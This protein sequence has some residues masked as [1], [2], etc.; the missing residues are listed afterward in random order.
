MPVPTTALES[1]FLEESPY[2]SYDQLD[3]FIGEDLL[4]EGQGSV[5]VARRSSDRVVLGHFILDLTSQ[6]VKDAYVRRLNPESYHEHLGHI[7]LRRDLRRVPVPYACRV[8]HEAV[9]FASRLGLRPHP[10]Y[11]N[12]CHVLAGVDTRTAFGAP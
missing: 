4:E 11:A 12:A 7:R 2:A 10:D 1:T 8:V 3:A 5:I 9:N 6:G